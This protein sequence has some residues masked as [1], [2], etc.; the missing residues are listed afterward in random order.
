M[1]EPRFR[2]SRLLPLVAALLVFSAGCGKDDPRGDLH[3]LRG[4]VEA[5]AGINLEDASVHVV[6]SGN[7]AAGGR[8]VKRAPNLLEFDLKVHGEEPVD[9]VVA[10]LPM[11]AFLGES[12]DATLERARAR[13]QT[14]RQI[15]TVGSHAGGLE[16]VRPG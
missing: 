6:R 3:H 4:R 16:N 9:L 14:S 13:S 5:P 1:A 10:T 15:L 8:I 7:F 12:L 2:R 11:V